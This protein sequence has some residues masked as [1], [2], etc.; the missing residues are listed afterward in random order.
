MSDQCPT[1][2][3]PDWVPISYG[4]PSAA[5]LAASHM[6]VIRL[7]GCVV[8]LESPTRACRK[9]DARWDDEIPSTGGT[10]AVIEAAREVALPLGDAD[11]AAAATDPVG[12]SAP[13]PVGRARTVMDNLPREVL[14]EFDFGPACSEC[15]GMM[16]RTG[17][18]YTCECGHETG[19]R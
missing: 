19:G 8:S 11:I 5:M 16:R 4:F 15:G 7:G 12:A 17:S 9:C 6:G 18:C 1:C 2:G 3:S 10:A 13:D 14:E